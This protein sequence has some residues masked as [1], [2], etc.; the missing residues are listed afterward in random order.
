ML[1]GSRLISSINQTIRKSLTFFAG[2]S[3]AALIVG[4]ILY[5]LIMQKTVSS[6]IQSLTIS[7][8]QNG[9]QVMEAACQISDS[10]Q[11]LAEGA[12]EQAAS[13]EETSASLEEISSMTRRNAQTA[14]SAKEFTA[15]PR[16]TAEAGAQ[17]AREMNQAMNGIKNAS[18]DVSKIIKTIDE[19]AFQ[20]NILALNAAVEAARAGEAGMGFAVVADEVRNLAQRSAKAAKENANMIEVS[21]KRSDDGVRVTEKVTAAIAEVAAKSRQV[22]QQLAGILEK[23]HQLDEQVGQI[24]T[25]SSEQSQGIWQVSTAVSQMDK[26]TQNNAAAAQELNGQAHVLKDAVNELQNLVGGSGVSSVPSHDH[27]S[28]MMATKRFVTPMVIARSKPVAPQV[29]SDLHTE[30]FDCQHITKAI[31]AHSKWKQRLSD[32]IH[33]SQS[34]TTPENV[35]PDNRCDFGKWLY[36]LSPA[37]KKSQHYD[38]IRTLHAEFHKEAAK[39]LRLALA[40][41]KAEAENAM[42][43]SS[44]FYNVSADLTAAL[45]SWERDSLHPQPR[46]LTVKSPLVPCQGS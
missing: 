3:L 5:L 21:I 11:S 23:V 24:A 8:E 25:A 16:L 30:Q 7:L 39:V 2:I 33:S 29:A 10:S 15:Q 45:K 13:L 1:Q 46:R 22:E 40:G 20:T 34:D 14:Q 4:E 32:A 9:C 37:E 12:S 17:G 36:S 31:A 42:A 43:L 44:P 35:E 18:S 19:I 6:K 38:D 41:Q 28:P 26:V 27:A